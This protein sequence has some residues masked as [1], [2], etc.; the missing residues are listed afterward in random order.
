MHFHSAF[1]YCC[2]LLFPAFVCLHA[3]PCNCVWHFHVA[4][5]FNILVN[6]ILLLYKNTSHLK[7]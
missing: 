7:C 2:M 3:E 1:H 5:S 6:M 4:T